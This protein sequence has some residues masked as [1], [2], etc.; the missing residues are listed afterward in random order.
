MQ[1]A[2][3]SARDG[4]CERLLKRYRSCNRQS[5]G[6]PQLW[7]ADKVICDRKLNSLGLEVLISKLQLEGFRQPCRISS[8][9]RQ[10]CR[11]SRLRPNKASF[12]TTVIRTVRTVLEQLQLTDSLSIPASRWFSS[13][14]CHQSTGTCCLHCYAKAS[15]KSQLEQHVANLI[16]WHHFIDGE[17]TLFNALHR[18]QGHGI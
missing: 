11:A 10:V 17:L 16:P 12:V 2:Q 4:T 6:S 1:H 14:F 8:I 13:L 9:C 15:V 18:Q 3:S 7:T 5:H